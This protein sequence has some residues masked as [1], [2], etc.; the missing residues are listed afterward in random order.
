M[1]LLVRRY[2]WS[3]QMFLVGIAL[4]IWLQIVLGRHGVAGGVVMCAMIG[5]ALHTGM[6]YTVW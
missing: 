5:I 3:L 2:K 4:R 1:G 6:W